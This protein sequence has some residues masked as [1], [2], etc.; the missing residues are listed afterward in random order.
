MSQSQLPNIKCIIITNG[1]SD[2][3]L[4]ADTKETKCTQITLNSIVNKYSTL[5]KP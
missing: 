1:G 2:D 4:T 5:P 3:F